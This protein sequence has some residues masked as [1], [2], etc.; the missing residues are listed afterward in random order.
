MENLTVFIINLKTSVDRRNYM[1]M[2]CQENQIDRYLSMQF[3]VK[4][5]RKSM[6][7]LFMLMRQRSK[8]SA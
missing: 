8:N 3:M 6:W 1:I 5:Y 7:L 4:I 2:L